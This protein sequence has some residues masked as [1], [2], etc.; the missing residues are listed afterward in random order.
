MR[1]M[2]GI[3]QDE[4]LARS[5]GI[6]YGVLKAPPVY[7]RGY[8]GALIET[9]RKSEKEKPRYCPNCGKPVTGRRRIY[10]DAVC[11]NQFRG[12]R[13]YAKKIAR[14]ESAADMIKAALGDADTGDGETAQNAIG[15]T[16]IISGEGGEVN[17]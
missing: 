9:L 7:V 3:A 14:L 13:K 12:R 11:S 6:T 1:Q 16:N 5:M 4:E 2:S 10:C 8:A 17:P 15:N